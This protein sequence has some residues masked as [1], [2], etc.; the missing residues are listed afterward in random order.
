MTDIYIPSYDE[1]M[2]PLLQAL[3]ELGGSGTIREL[4]AE[5]AQIMALSDEQLE[6]LHDEERGARTEFS[7]RLAWTRTYLKKVGLIINSSRGVWVMTALGRQQHHIDEG[8]VVNQVR[9]MDAK[10]R[11]TSAGDIPE[12]DDILT[13]EDE[14]LEILLNI[15]PDAFERL[16]QQLLR[17]SGFTQVEVTGEPGDGGIDGVGV[18][19]LNGL[20]S[21][22]VLFQAKRWKGSVGASIVRDFR[23][24]MAG[25]ADKGLLVTTSTFTQDAQREA[26]RDGADAID[27]VDGEALVN[28]LKELGLGVRTEVVEKV[29]IDKDWFTGI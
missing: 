27:L 29:I 24:A 5:V 12:P 10:S 22:K 19:Q 13:W 14:L 11:S 17:E 20:I 21:F 7:Y 26:T 8:A 18:L 2:N 1:M 28:K 9:Q 6:L 15:T 3:R 16:V 4:E 25:R 23:G